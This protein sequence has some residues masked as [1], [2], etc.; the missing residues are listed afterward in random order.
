V[1]S[2]PT[3]S[4]WTGKATAGLRERV[5]PASVPRPTGTTTPVD[6]S[7]FGLPQRPSLGPNLVGLSRLLAERLQLPIAPMPV[8]G[9]SR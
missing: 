7:P 8:V 6:D 3:R 1:C 5:I 4:I 9:A 2:H